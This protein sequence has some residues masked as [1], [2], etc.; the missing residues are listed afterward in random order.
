MY[1]P[2]N[3]AIKSNRL[4]YFSWLFIFHINFFE[5]ISIIE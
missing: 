2:F 1:I 5:I 3:F 4:M